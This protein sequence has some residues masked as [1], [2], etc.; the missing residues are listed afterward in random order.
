MASPR[1]AI[2]MTAAAGIVGLGACVAGIE[3]RAGH[4]FARVWW[5]FGRKASHQLAQSP[6]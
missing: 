4:R 1:A 5:M 2:A 3:G 6:S